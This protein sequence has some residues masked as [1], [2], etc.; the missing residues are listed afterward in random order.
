MFTYLLLSALTVPPVVRACITPDPV[1]LFVFCDVSSGFPHH[2]L[3]LFVSLSFLVWMHI[4]TT[5]TVAAL[6]GRRGLHIRCEV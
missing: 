1:H 6:D 5:E 2:F 3:F 4:K